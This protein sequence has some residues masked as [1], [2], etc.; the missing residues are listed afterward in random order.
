MSAIF[1]LIN[2]QTVIIAGNEEFKD[3][4]V[5]GRVP[6]EEGNDMSSLVLSLAQ[7][8]A[9]R[10]VDENRQRTVELIASADPSVDLI[11]LPEYSMYSD[12]AQEAPEEK[13]SERLDGKFITA[14][15][16]A[17]ARNSVHVVVGF[18]ETNDGDRPFNTIAHVNSSGKLA[19]IYRKIHLY[20]AFGYRESDHLAPAEI[21]QPTV[22]DIDG[23]QVGLATCYDLR[24]PEISRWLVDAGADIIV[25]P[26]AWAVG[27]M[28]ELHWET[29][30]RARA[31]ENTV[32]FAAC[33]QTGPHCSG[34]S[35]IVDPMGAV[36]ASAGE[37][38][39]SI[40]TA[41]V[42]LSRIEAVRASNPSLSNRRFTVTPR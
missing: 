1:L 13:Y 21:D 8:G 15:R 22:F 31:I 33:G 32:Y 38:T 4:V 23:V 40:A 3:Y 10:D 25:L 37:R 5:P 42:T 41:E 12:M 26:A 24:F 16:D 7:F 11:V 6:T 30:A 19:N 28:K 36:I 18:T 35:I 9:T 27:P 34:Q 17:A 39:D 2:R 29:L 20:D 14:V